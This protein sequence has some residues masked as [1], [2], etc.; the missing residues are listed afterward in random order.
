MNKKRLIAY[1]LM[2]W[3]LIGGLVCVFVFAGWEV[4]LTISGAA[5]FAVSMVVS[6]NKGLDLLYKANRED[7]YRKLN[8]ERAK[9]W[10]DE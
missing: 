1:A 10:E 3:P 7:F 4:A 6:L 9:E 5:L 8:E 2:A